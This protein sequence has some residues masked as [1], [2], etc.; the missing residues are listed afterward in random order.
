MADFSIWLSSLT[1][2]RLVTSVNDLNKQCINKHRIFLIK[3]H[4]VCSGEASLW[5]NLF[6]ISLNVRRDCQIV[7]IE[8]LFTY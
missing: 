2:R 4:S 7:K 8:Y 1:K 3:I 5:L 6:F